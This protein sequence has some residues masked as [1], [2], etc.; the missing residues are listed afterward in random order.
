MIIAQRGKSCGSG[1][2]RIGKYCVR[3]DIVE[4]I[5]GEGYPTWLLGDFLAAIGED[6]VEERRFL[7][8]WSAKD[9]LLT[10]FEEALQPVRRKLL[11][12]GIV[13]K[14]VTSVE[15]PWQCPEGQQCNALK[16]FLTALGN[17]KRGMKTARA[18][19]MIYSLDL[20]FDI[21]KATERKFAEWAEGVDIHPKSLWMNIYMLYDYAYWYG[22]KKHREAVEKVIESAD[23]DPCERV[24][25]KWDDKVEIYLKGADLATAARINACLHRLGIVNIRVVRSCA[26]VVDGEKRQHI[27]ACKIIKEGDKIEL[28]REYGEPYG[29]FKI[30]S[31]RERRLA[32]RALMRL[33]RLKK[34]L[35]DVDYRNRIYECIRCAVNI[36]LLDEDLDKDSAMAL[37][38]QCA[39]NCPTSSALRNRRNRRIPTLCSACKL[40]M[41]GFPAVAPAGSTVKDLKRL[42]YLLD[43]FTMATEL[44]KRPQ[45]GETQE[46]NTESST[47][48]TIKLESKPLVI[49]TPDWNRIVDAVV[50][51]SLDTLLNAF[52][53]REVMIGSPLLSDVIRLWIDKPYDLFYISLFKATRVDDVQVSQLT[54]KDL[55]NN[56][57]LVVKKDDGKTEVYRDVIF[58]D[59]SFEYNSD[60]V[61]S[62]SDR[63]LESI[64]FFEVNDNSQ[65]LLSLIGLRNI[66]I[67]PIDY[68]EAVVYVNEKPYFIFSG[69]I[70]ITKDKI[71]I[72][73]TIPLRK[74]NEEERKL[75]SEWIEVFNTIAKYI[76]EKT[77]LPTPRSCISLVISGF[78]KTLISYPP[79][80]RIEI[81][82]SYDRYYYRDYFGIGLIKKL[83]PDYVPDLDAELIK[84]LLSPKVL[85]IYKK[86]ANVLVNAVGYDT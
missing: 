5:K 53:A 71:K 57:L 51:T 14:E 11:A 47:E 69:H 30:L 9:A 18:A 25:W 16:V 37:C 48:E 60:V 24:A 43:A 72:K 76:L 83:F 27:Y 8:L 7:D 73:N 62:F 39:D 66:R 55:L 40:L 82:S 12:Q 52:E 4:T 21:V 65:R 64:M 85:Q 63:N 44:L 31:T 26:V 46:K 74:S 22:D 77:P 10:Q 34:M 3:S 15:I 32:R 54:V 84:K 2:K 75:A 33:H 1:F 6:E 45:T 19:H 42:H 17:V 79:V 35:E 70:E 36:M 58:I 68:S 20:A 80:P 78:A 13:A 28:K 81:Y 50:N 61:F 49:N 29:K 38:Q 56:R 67:S 41:W 23:K 86:I 59:S